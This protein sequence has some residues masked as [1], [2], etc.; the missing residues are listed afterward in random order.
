MIITVNHVYYVGWF[1]AVLIGFVVFYSVSQRFYFQSYV[2]FSSVFV[3]VLAHRSFSTSYQCH[4]P[5]HLHTLNHIHVWFIRAFALRLHMLPTVY[6]EAS[7][8]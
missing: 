4:L 5:T 2:L 6:E 8:Q 3:F 7:K 1:L